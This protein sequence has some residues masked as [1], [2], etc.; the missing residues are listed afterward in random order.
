MATLM[1]ETPSHYKGSLS[2]E[3]SLEEDL[4]PGLILCIKYIYTH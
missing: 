4:L 3:N 1:L 2:E